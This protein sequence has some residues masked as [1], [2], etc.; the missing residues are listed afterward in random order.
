MPVELCTRENV[1]HSAFT[2]NGMQV[3]D[4]HKGTLTLYKTEQ[5]YAAVFQESAPSKGMR[6]VRTMGPTAVKVVAQETFIVGKMIAAAILFGGS[7]VARTAVAAQQHKELW[8]WGD[9]AELKRLMD[10][11]PG[12]DGSYF[13][14]F[15][16]SEVSVIALEAPKGFVALHIYNREILLNNLFWPADL[17]AGAER[18]EVNAWKNMIQ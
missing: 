6:N 18:D 8:E 1:W 13:V 14:D 9:G 4:K 2:G 17:D 7:N 11:K 12:I 10:K 15:K 3:C 5:G 16:A